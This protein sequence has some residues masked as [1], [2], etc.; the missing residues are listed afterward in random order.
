M[1]EIEKRLWIHLCNYTGRCN[2][3]RNNYSRDAKAHYEFNEGGAKR[4]ICLW[5][6][7]VNGLCSDAIF[8]C[9]GLGN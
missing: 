5:Q 1:T 6:L 3:I 4:S 2:W 7:D 9:T 8:V